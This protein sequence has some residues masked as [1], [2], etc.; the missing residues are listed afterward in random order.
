MY[1]HDLFDIIYTWDYNYRNM[2]K[3]EFPKYSTVTS[4]YTY[5]LMMQIYSILLEMS[6]KIKMTFMAFRSMI[7]IL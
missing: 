2:P 6:L 7:K 4:K 3:T 5:A 1:L